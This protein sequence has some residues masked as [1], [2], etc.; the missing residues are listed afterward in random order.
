MGKAAQ[1]R[2]KQEWAREKL[3]VDNARKM[4]RNYFI[5]P[6]DEEYSYILN[7]ARKNWKNFWHQLC[8]VERQPQEHQGNLWGC[9]S[10]GKT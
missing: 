2:E 1:I 4:R 7:K 8:H 3:K 10:Y 6:N 5:D 9:F